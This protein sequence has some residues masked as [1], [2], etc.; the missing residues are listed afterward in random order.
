VLP[1]PV[2]P[3]EPQQRD[4]LIPFRWRNFGALVGERY[5][6]IVKGVGSE[7]PY[8]YELYDLKNDP[9][10]Q[11]NLVKSKSTVAN[12]MTDRFKAFNQSVEA[13]IAGQDYPAGEV[14]SPDQ[15]PRR[16]P[17]VPAYNKRFG[18]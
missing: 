12:R 4:T 13:S 14:T 17:N 8:Q 9:K 7:K 6:L 11:T 15:K 10:E 2:T 5:K 18:E 3:I 1:G 16:W